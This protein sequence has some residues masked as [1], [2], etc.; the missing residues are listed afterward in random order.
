MSTVLTLSN[1]S[2]LDAQ[3]ISNKL[4]KQSII[5]IADVLSYIFN[6]SLEQGIFPD[7]LKISKVIPIHKSGS[8]HVMSNYR[9]ISLVS[10]F[11]KIFE[12]IVKTRLLNFCSKHSIIIDEQ[13]GFKQGSS[14]EQALTTYLN[15]IYNNA[16]KDKTTLSI[17]I[18]FSK[19]FDSI[20]HQILLKK[21][22]FYG[23]RGIPLNW[24]KS[25][26]N[27]RKQY[28][29]INTA[30]STLKFVT[31]GVPQGSILGPL[32]FN[33]FIND[34]INSSSNVKF[35]VY[36]DD[37]TI[38][39]N[40]NDVKYLFRNMELALQEI[41]SWAE[42]NKLLIN[43]NKTK[44]MTYSKKKGSTN[45]ILKINNN[46]IS[47]VDS[48]KLLGVHID[49]NLNFKNHVD[50]ISQKIYRSLRIINKLKH[51][52]LK[53]TLII[54]YYSLIFSHLYYCNIIWGSTFK[55]YLQKIYSVQKKFCYTV[56]S[57]YPTLHN[58]DIENCFNKLKI[59]TI[60]ELNIYK[61]AIFF[62]IKSL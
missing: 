33:I 12:R 60:F 46:I 16:N 50:F 8:S 45:L 11:S 15:D 55:T 27:D 10:D 57:I 7:G 54:L 42:S 38:S 53:S 9:P 1:S 2:A 28:V 22:E 36:A 37:T 3:N 21:L 62:F 32:L 18:D 13:F 20:N 56:K 19:A 61:A 5:Y 48:F 39:A 26:L 29:K 25:Y 24:F 51:F 34:I 4:L 40:S 58:T 14:T 47:K 23:I 44:F 30:I 43:F 41:Y 59:R 49:P 31:S 17:F 52:L 35:I 6:L